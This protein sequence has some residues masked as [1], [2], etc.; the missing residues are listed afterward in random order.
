MVSVAVI[1][2]GFIGRAWAITF[3]RA[4]HHVALWDEEEGPADPL[5]SSRRDRSHCRPSRPIDD[6]PDIRGRE[7]QRGL[8]HVNGSTDERPIHGRE[9][10][11]LFA[12]HGLG[13]RGLPE[14]GFAG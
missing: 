4:G 12:I 3:A 13:V 14:P 1:G 7:S 5:R 6:E 2:S 10:G 9:A 8:C 11:C